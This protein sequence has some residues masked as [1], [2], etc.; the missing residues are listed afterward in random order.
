M[1]VG[2][3]EQIFSALISELKKITTTAGYNFT[4]RNVYDPSVAI[5]AMNEFPS[6]NIQDGSE[7]CANA[8]TAAHLRVGG[9]EP[10]L[11]NAFT[12]QLDCILS[13]MN[14]PRQERNKML[15]DIQKHFGINHTIGNT[16]LTC[17]YAGSEPWG[18]HETKPLTGITVLL[19][20]WYRQRLELPGILK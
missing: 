13:V 2:A 6:V 1:S 8:E 5:D 15:A 10:I 14:N 17:V 20:I 18:I 19:K 11:E 3:R 7:D 12:V 9:N 4:I 16:A